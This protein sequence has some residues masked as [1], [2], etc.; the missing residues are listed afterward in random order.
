MVLDVLLVGHEH[1]DLEFYEFF[2]E[3]HVGGSLWNHLGPHNLLLKSFL[4][5]VALGVTVLLNVPNCIQLVHL[6]LR[7]IPK[8]KIIFT[9]REVAWSSSPEL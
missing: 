7:K 9:S 1:F 5:L 4:V 3:T 8:N 2:C 6:K